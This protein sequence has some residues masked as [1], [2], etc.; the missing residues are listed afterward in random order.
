MLRRRGAFLFLSGYRSQKGTSSEFCR[1]CAAYHPMSVLRNPARPS[2][3]EEI[4]EKAASWSVAFVEVEEIDSINIYWASI[5][6]MQ[7][8]VEGLG[9]I[10]PHLLIDAKS[11]KRNSDPAAGDYQGSH[12]ICQ[13]RGRLHCGQGL[14]RCADTYAR[15]ASSRLRLRRSQGLSRA[16]SLPAAQRS[17]LPTDA[18]S[19]LCVRSWLAAI[20][21]M[22]LLSELV[23]EDG[24]SKIERLRGRSMAGAVSITSWTWRTASK[25]AAIAFKRSFFVVPAGGTVGRVHSANSGGAR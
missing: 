10:P 8:A 3:E 20:A 15:H 4:K 11:L 24:A 9:L 22:A 16:R 23:R 25:S 14:A 5:L 6:V 12:Q 21:A 13:H 17:A 1:G 7:R 19:A 2:R 18:R